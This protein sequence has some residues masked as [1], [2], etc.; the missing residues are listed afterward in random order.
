M[1]ILGALLAAAM[2]V[3]RKPVVAVASAA[4]ALAAVLPAQPERGPGDLTQRLENFYEAEARRKVPF[5]AL[6]AA[7]PSIDIVFL[8][9]CSMSWS[10]LAY[11]GLDRHPFLAKF[12]YWF[13]RFNSAT[14]YSDVAAFRLL[15][16]PCGQQSHSDLYDEAPQGCYL[17]DELRRLGYR[18]YTV[19]NHTGEYAEMAKRLRRFGHADALMKTEGLPASAMNFDDTPIFNDYATLERWWSA[20]QAS[21]AERAVVYYNTITLHDGAYAP[22]GSSTSGGDYMGRYRESADRLF[23]DFEKFFGLVEAS[24]RNALVVFVPEHGR[25]LAGT[26]IQRPQLREI[27][28]PELTLVPLGIK[29]I[30]PGWSSGPSRTVSKPV[31]YHAIAH[32]IART[33]REPRS[34]RDRGAFQ[35]IIDQVPE[36]PYLSENHTVGRR[37]AQEGDRYYVEDKHFR[38]VV[39]PSR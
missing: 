24:G 9:V 4:L 25:G 19:L 13:S 33:L 18:T 16:S 15:R 35:R 20:R 28:V 23:R 6:A 26:S 38:W 1:V 7:A 27:S 32:V 31:S 37:V 17:L 12:D 36:T 3:L 2:F 8:H 10:D 22:G 11:A 39:L 5:E 14:S 34:G 21:R 30:G 29:V